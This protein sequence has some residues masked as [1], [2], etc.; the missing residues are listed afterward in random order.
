MGP[1][2]TQ[3]SGRDTNGPMSPRNV[4]QYHAANVLLSSLA[5][6]SLSSPRRCRIVVDLASKSR[7]DSVSRPRLSVCASASGR[8]PSKGAVPPCACRLP[9]ACRPPAQL[10]S[11]SLRPL[12]LLWLALAPAESTSLSQLASSCLSLSTFFHPFPF[13]HLKTPFLPPS[14]SPS[15]FPAYHN[16]SSSTLAPF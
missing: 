7:L 5:R 4:S 8:L 16:I 14:P 3:I 12:A 11:R 6:C 1:S 15:L 9:A 2:V 10:P 13:P